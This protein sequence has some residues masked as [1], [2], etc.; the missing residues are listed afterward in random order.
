MISHDAALADPPDAASG[1]AD[2]A[3]EAVRARLLRAVLAHRLAPGAKLS[4]EGVAAACGV[5]RTVARAALR[6]LAH[7]GVV[8]IA[9]N[10]GAFVASPAPREAREVFEARALVEPHVARLAAA[11]CDAAALARLRAHLAE[12]RA[13]LDAGAQDRAVYLSGQFHVLIAGVAG[14][15]TL[16]SFVALLIA[17]SSLAVALY[18]RRAEALCQ[19]CAHDALTEALAQGDAAGAEAAMRRHLDD[20]VAGLDFSPRAAPARDLAQALDMT[21]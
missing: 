10:R 15:R 19:S 12:E 4:E 11:R 6:A 1:A 16:A 13:A 7:D 17:R 14:Q 8:E 2:A 9:R 3:S 20:L 21:P 5:G 18:W